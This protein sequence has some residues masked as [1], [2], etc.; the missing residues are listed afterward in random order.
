MR[1]T[2]IPYG[3]KVLNVVTGNWI[4]VSQDEFVNTGDTITLV[5]GQT[6]VVDDI[7]EDGTVYVKPN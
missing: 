1:K 4:E 2:C 3:S 6:Y 5:N 7:W